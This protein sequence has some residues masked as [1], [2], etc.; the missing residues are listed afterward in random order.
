M[1][2]GARIEYNTFYDIGGWDGASGAA[3]SD[4]ATPGAVVSDTLPA[5]VTNATWTCAAAG[6]A[7]VWVGNS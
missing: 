4:G 7:G 1:R 3:G 2:R 6:C 5:N